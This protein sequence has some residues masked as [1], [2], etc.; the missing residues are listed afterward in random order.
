MIGSNLDLILVAASF[1]NDKETHSLQLTKNRGYLFINTHAAEFQLTYF[2]TYNTFTVHIVKG[3]TTIT[4]DKDTDSYV[5]KN[6]TNC[7]GTL[8]MLNP[9]NFSIV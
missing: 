8:F 9:E 6:T 3:N 5:F 1:L 7:R 4:Y 2:N